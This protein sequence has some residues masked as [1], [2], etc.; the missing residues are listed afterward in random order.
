MTCV[1]RNWGLVVR[2]FLLGRPYWGT[3]LDPTSSPIA[4]ATRAVSAGAAENLNIE[5][6]NFLAQRIAINPKQVGSPDL[7]TA[8]CGK[9]H[10]QKRMLDFAQHA[11]V[12][13]RWRQLGPKLAK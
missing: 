9:G 10:R 3:P 12:E 4:P 2:D 1:A 5:I 11:V 13:A 6:A 8:G 7:V